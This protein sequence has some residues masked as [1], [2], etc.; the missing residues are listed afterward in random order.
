MLYLNLNGR[1]RPLGT[2][3][4]AAYCCSLRFPAF[5]SAEIPDSFRFAIWGTLGLPP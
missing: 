2:R 1:F 5:S 3:I 4:V